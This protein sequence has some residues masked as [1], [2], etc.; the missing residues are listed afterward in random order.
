MRTQYIYFYDF[1][2]FRYS[3]ISVVFNSK[4]FKNVYR[5][6]VNFFRGSVSITFW[7]RAPYTYFYFFL[8]WEHL[9]LIQ[10]F[11][12]E[13]FKNTFRI[14]IFMDF[15]HS[16]LL[17]WVVLHLLEQKPTQ[18][19]IITTWT[20]T[21]YSHFWLSLCTTTNKQPMRTLPPISYSS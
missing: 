13:Y 18:S 9:C 17:V 14:L 2:N 19:S 7:L 10:F 6:S 20:S 8:N 4:N 15:T 5:I 12:F 3:L 1:F 11:I 16:Y 21:L